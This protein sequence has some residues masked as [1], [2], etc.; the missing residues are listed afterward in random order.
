MPLRLYK[1]KT[2]DGRFIYHYRGTVAGNRLRGTTGTADKKLAERTISEIE[3]R[4]HKGRLFDPEEV[5]TFPQAV[6]LYLKAGKP[7]KYLG[8]IE[9]YWKDT[10]VKAMKAGLIR[11]SAIELYPDATD[12]TRNRQVITPTQAVINY[13]A[14]E[15]EL[16]APVR[17]KRFKED[18]KI[19]TPVTVEWLDTFTSHAR[20]LIAALADYMFAT[21]SR[22]SEARR[23]TWKDIDFN[24]RT[25][26]VRDSKNRKE[27]IVH[28]Q[29][30]LMVGLANLPRDSEPFSG[31][32]KSEMNLRRFWDQDVATAAEAVEGFERL[33]FHCCRHGFATKMLRDGKDPKT[34]AFLGGWDDIQLF[35]E[36]YVHEIQDAT[37]TDEIFDTHLTRD[38]RSRQ[39]KQ[40]LKRQ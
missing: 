40:R 36:T 3:N 19:K 10:K 9:D 16:C 34:A 28:M 1:R 4:H 2:R 23:L 22:I 15:L 17:V 8:K 37:L 31:R 14:E 35:M 24:R 30:R 26:L 39:Q 29:Q 33:T 25:I 5:L 21:A 6:E 27:R 18:R 13:C 20:P 7:E 11:Q 32:G 38:K 12:A